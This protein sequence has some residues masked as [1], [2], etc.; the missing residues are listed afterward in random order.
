MLAEF[1]KKN[2]EL[3]RRSSNAVLKN[4]VLVEDGF[5]LVAFS[6]KGQI[7]A[8]TPNNSTS[9]CVSPIISYLN[10]TCL[11]LFTFLR[12]WAIE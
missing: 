10:L 1:F 8:T 7:N 4:S 3:H 6:E 12:S 5:E 11:L 2:L 9:G